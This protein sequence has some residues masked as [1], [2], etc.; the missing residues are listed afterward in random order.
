[1]SRPFGANTLKRDRTAP[2]KYPGRVHAICCRRLRRRSQGAAGWGGHEFRPIGKQLELFCY[3]LERLTCFGIDPCQRK[4]AIL[5]SK[6][7]IVACS[8][9]GGIILGGD[10]ALDEEG[11]RF[12]ILRR[13]DQDVTPS[14]AESPTVTMQSNPAGLLKL[15]IILRPEVSIPAPSRQPH[16][17]R[18]VSGSAL[19]CA[20]SERS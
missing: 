17:A 5:L 15:G 2:G 20:G 13:V 9:P 3:R 18:L 6:G 11:E 1:M 7:Q 10:G 19:P 14:S 16:P 12:A 8:L 4:G